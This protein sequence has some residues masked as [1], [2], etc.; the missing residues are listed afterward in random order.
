MKQWVATDACPLPGAFRGAEVCVEAGRWRVRLRHTP[1]EARRLHEHPNAPHR[2]DRRHGLRHCGRRSTRDGLIEEL[3]ALVDK[4]DS[5]NTAQLTAELERLRKEVSNLLDLAA[6][7]VSRETLAPKI[8]ERE[9]QIEKLDVTVRMPRQ[10]PPNIEKL[11]VALQQRAEE[12][13]AELRA[14]PKVARLLLRRL[15]G[16]MPCGTVRCPRLNGLSGKRR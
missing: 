8:R 10:Q 14:E 13:K 15:V 2:R 5:D 12:W 9:A 16:P 11:R 4:G 6:S 3:L 7:G 1:E